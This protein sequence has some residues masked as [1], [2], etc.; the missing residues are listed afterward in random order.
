M[1]TDQAF[2]L[3][4]GALLLAALVTILGLAVLGAFHIGEIV[5]GK[6]RTE[7]EYAQS[8]ARAAAEK[9]GPPRG[10]R[11]LPDLMGALSQIDNALTGLD[12]VRPGVAV[13]LGR[14]ERPNIKPVGGKR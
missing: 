12:H 1:T 11:P 3:A 8:L 2:H 10:W 6:R 5:S 9:Y 7:L 14:R 4:E 13:S